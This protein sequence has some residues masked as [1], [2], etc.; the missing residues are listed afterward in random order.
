[1]FGIMNKKIRNMIPYLCPLV[2]LYFL[3]LKTETKEIISEIMAVIISIYLSSPFSFSFFF[4]CLSFNLFIIR[5]PVKIINTVN[6][7]TNS[8]PLWSL[9]CILPFSLSFFISTVSLLMRQKN[10]D[11]TS[12]T[13]IIDIP[14]RNFIF[15]PSFF[16]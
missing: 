16:S 15:P 13:I 6:T 2:L 3:S 8:I 11:T 5:L 10:A 4:S 14:K 7:G 1:M 9:S 12:A